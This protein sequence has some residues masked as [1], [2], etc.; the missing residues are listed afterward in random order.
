MTAWIE[1]GRALVGGALIGVST[2]LFLAL[3]G[4]VAGISGITGGLVVPVRG[5]VAWRAMFVAGLLVGGVLV[6]LFA[7]RAFGP[8]TVPLSLVALAGVLVGVGTR[9]GNGCT[10]GHG[11]CGISRLSP[12]SIVATVT[13][14]TTGMVSVLLSR[15]AQGGAR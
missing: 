2:S 6:A 5:D 10:S 13:F 4:R 12:R 14:V 9:L 8:S 3:N 11:V 7:P 15:A 1:W